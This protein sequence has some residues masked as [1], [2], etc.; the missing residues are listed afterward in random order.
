MSKIGWIGVCI[1]GVV[2]FKVA[3]TAILG[4]KID[5]TLF[6]VHLGVY[7]VGLGMCVFSRRPKV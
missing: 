5:P 6:F 4:V 3:M 2:V 7:L 1:M